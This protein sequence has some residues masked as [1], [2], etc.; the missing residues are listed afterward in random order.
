MGFQRPYRSLWP[1]IMAVFLIPFALMATQADPTPI[2]A[3]PDIVVT[4]ATLPEAWSD[5]AYGQ[6]DVPQAAIDRVPRQSFE[7]LLPLIPGAQ[8]FRRAD[9][10][11]SNPTAQGLTLRA[12][13]GNA[14][15]R[16]LVLRDGV[17]VA[18]PFFG[19]VPY[20]SLLLGNMRRVSVTP[21]AGAGSFGSGAIAG[22]VEIES[23]DPWQATPFATLLSVG[24]LDTVSAS[25]GVGGRLG[26]GGVRFAAAGERS[27]GFWTTPVD[28][29]VAASVPARYRY[30]AA[31]LA[32]SA[33]VGYGR[34]DVRL[35]LFD[36]RR[37]L[38][39]AGAD[40]RSQGADLSAR[41]VRS[42]DGDGASGWGVEAVG[43]VQ[44]REFSATTISATTFRPVL[45]QRATPSLGWGGKLELRPPVN[46]LS[47]L[48][49]GVDVRGAEGRTDEIALAASGA[50]TLRRRAGGQSVLAGAYVEHDV[51]AGPVVLGAGLR[52]DRWW[53]RDGTLRETGATGATVTDQTFADRNLTRMTARTAISRQIS[54]GL[55]LR[56]SAYRGFRVPTLNELY[57]P[58]VVFPVTTRA[59]ATLSPERLTGIEA[60]LMVE[61]VTGP[62]LSITAFANRVEGA[63]ANV[64]IGP[65]LRQRANLPAIRARGLEFVGG[66][67]F[68]DGGMVRITA[69]W[70]DA[71]VE[72]GAIAPAL[73][74]LRPAQ[75][76]RLSGSALLAFAGPGRTQNSI[77]LRHGGRQ[78]EDD[79]NVDPLPAYTTLDV[80]SRWALGDRLSLTLSAENL[81][82]TR[83]VTRNSGGSID[84]GV[85]RSVRLTLRLN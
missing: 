30:G 53:L 63:I 58:F 71:Q 8:Q 20:N 48:R 57:R 84:L 82:G 2:P 51:R 78:F 70:T 13:G 49:L 38:R 31:E 43:W 54:R 21:G 40:S 23:V 72:G 65:N 32:T 28:Q 1:I 75:V 19:S 52:V 6:F 60:G 85:P 79:R 46:H 42:G 47:T 26:Q 61:H 45:N 69:A 15:A 41:Y 55:A 83:I 10:R 27:D 14:A 24:S 22:V 56:A 17:P 16:T 5:T 25:L 59:N 7:E 12:L 35:G 11:S 62:M 39:F 3:P 73:D 36:D 9:S 67:N 77:S 81:T 64:S 37:T 29:R 44:L 68:G 74:R 76:P 50:V 18:D 4:A 34:L 66:H 33:L 80:A